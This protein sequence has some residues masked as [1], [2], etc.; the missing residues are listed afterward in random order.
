M[1]NTK[2][3]YSNLGPGWD[4]KIIL[5]QAGDGHRRRFHLRFLTVD[6]SSETAAKKFQ[7]AW[8]SENLQQ[9]REKRR[10]V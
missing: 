8:R 9:S 7:A 10:N 6:A 1:T 4:G 5:R 2:I 3:E